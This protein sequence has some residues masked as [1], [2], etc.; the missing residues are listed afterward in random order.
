MLTPQTSASSLIQFRLLGGVW[1]SYFFS[2]PDPKAV[3]EQYGALIG[4]PMWQ[5]TWAFGFHLCRYGRACGFSD[6]Q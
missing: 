2:G 4:L 5:P 3:V 1:D 6:R